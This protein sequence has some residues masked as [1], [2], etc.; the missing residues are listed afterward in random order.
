MNN[1]IAQDADRSFNLTLG[2]LMFSDPQRDRS[3]AIVVAN[4]KDWTAEI[5]PGD[6]LRIDF[7]ERTIEEGLYVV[8]LDDDWIGFRFFHRSP[9]LHM[10]DDVGSYPITPA[11]MQSIEVVGRVKDIYRS[12]RPQ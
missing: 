9:E 11:I 6:L 3:N 12:T 2:R 10:K 7:T 5:E 8:T 4:H 1:L